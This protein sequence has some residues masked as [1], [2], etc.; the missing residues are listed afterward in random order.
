[1]LIGG[2]EGL[3]SLSSR[4]IFSQIFA[5]CAILSFET[6]TM[7]ACALRRLGAKRPDSWAF[8]LFSLLRRWG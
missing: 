7:M 8:G 4:C 3:Q 6:R 1:L 5:R 2:A